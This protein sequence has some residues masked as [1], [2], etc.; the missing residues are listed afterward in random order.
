MYCGDNARL[1]TGIPNAMLKPLA[2]PQEARMVTL[3][4]EVN[5]FTLGLRGRLSYC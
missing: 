2:A 5:Q 1:R 4:S 3:S